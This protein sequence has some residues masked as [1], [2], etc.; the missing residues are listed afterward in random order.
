MRCFKRVILLVCLF[1]AS[2]FA[3]NDPNIIR[4]AM[5]SLKNFGQAKADDPPKLHFIADRIAEQAKCGVCAVDELQDADGSAFITLQGAVCQSAGTQIAMALS[6]RVGG[7]RKEQFGFFWNPQLVDK[8]VDVN[9]F[10]CDA[11]E[12]D[13]AY[14][15]FKAKLGFDFTLCVFHTRPDSAPAELRSELEYLDEVFAAIQQKDS[16]ENDVIF[17]GDFNASPYIRPYQTCAIADCIGPFAQFVHWVIRDV[18]TNVLQTKVYDNVFFDVRYT[19]NEYIPGGQNVIRVDQMWGDF[20]STDPT[21]PSD[22]ADRPK[23]LQMKVMDH[24]PVYA[25]FRADVDDDD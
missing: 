8:I 14:A 4:I 17:L 3:G 19:N 25:E 1:S 23:Y 16:S 5:V 11:I 15:T 2:V 10:Y 7:S 21:A 20:T 22:P 13:P 12:R 24:C 6:A 9:V 18:P